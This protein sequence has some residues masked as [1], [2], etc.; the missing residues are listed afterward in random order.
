VAFN[1]AFQFTH[2]CLLMTQ[3][4]CIFLYRVIALF[5]FGASILGKPAQ[6][7]VGGGLDDLHGFVQYRRSIL[8]DPRVLSATTRI[9]PTS[10]DRLCHAFRMAGIWADYQFLGIVGD[11]CP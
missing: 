9:T 6:L 2:Y 8:H 10:V 4:Q 1:S 11:S 5:F 3:E 7:A